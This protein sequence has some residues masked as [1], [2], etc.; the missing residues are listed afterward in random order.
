MPIMTLVPRSYDSTRSKALHARAQRVAPFVFGHTSVLLSFFVAFSVSF[1]G[2]TQASTT[3]DALSAS[4]LDVVAAIAKAVAGD[5]VF[6]PA[7]TIRWDT[8]AIVDKAI[9]IQG[10]GVGVTILQDS[11][12]NTSSMFALLPPPGKVIRLTGIEFQAGTRAAMLSVGLICTSPPSGDGSNTNSVRI[13]HCKFNLLNRF[14]IQTENTFGVIDHNEFQLA[15]PGIGIYV[16]NKTWGGSSYGDGSYSAPTGFGSDKF[17]FIE[18][19]TFAFQTGTHYAV[20]DSLGGSRWV[21]RHNNVTRGWCE[22]HGTES[23]GRFRGTRAVE[24]YNNTFTANGGGGLITNMRSGTG[25][26]YNNTATGYITPVT[27]SLQLD[28]EIGNFGPWGRAD[29]SNAWDVNLAGGPFYSGTVSSA[30]SLTVT[31]PGTGWAT[32]QWANYQIKKL[33]GSGGAVDFS[34]IRSN[35]NNTITFSAGWSGNL[36]FAAND[37]FEIR[38]V[39]QALDQPG[40]VLGS[41]LSGDIPSIP[42]GWNN[43]VTEPFYS[44][45]NTYENGAHILFGAHA[46]SVRANEH[47]LNDTQLSGYTPYMYP[48]PLVTGGAVASPP[49]PANLRVISGP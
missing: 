24:I 22:A 6:I 21:F 36:N 33:S 14:N 19:N 34:T 5:T 45:N 1:S 49:A 46:G 18:D 20:I 15:S 32:N 39:L 38:K 48:H 8:P 41:L 13:D 28:R 37:T 31:V 10:S 42:S 3:I 4:R 47:Y 27:N 2:P 40:R 43:Q 25:V 23:G 30:G 7:G 17:L 44:W 12:L 26:I 11:S 29:G 9:T 16:F 35:T